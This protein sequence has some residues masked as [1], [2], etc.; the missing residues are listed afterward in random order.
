M[1]FSRSTAATALPRGI[2]SSFN[3]RTYAVPRCGHSQRYFILILLFVFSLCERKNEQQLGSTMLR[4]AKRR[5]KAR[6]RK[7]CNVSHH[8]QDL[9][10]AGCA[11]P[12]GF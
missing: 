11:E 5:L 12:V 9:N 2:F 1:E 10:P 3:N 4:Q 8:V 6:L 7:S